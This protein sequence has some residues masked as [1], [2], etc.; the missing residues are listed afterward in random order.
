MLQWNFRSSASCPRCGI[1]LEDKDHIT[2]CPE[3][4]A[5]ST[6]QT[7]LK[8][9]KRWFRESNTAHEVAEA[10]IWGLTQWCDPQRTTAPPA[11]QFI[12]DQTVL[13]WGRLF[14][15]WLATSWRHHQEEQWRCVRSHR[16]G[17]RW[18]AELIKKLWNV[19]WDM[20]AHQ[21]GIL[22]TSP[23]A[24]QEILEKHVND[25]IRAIYE[26]GTQALPCDA[27][28]LLQKTQE[29]MLQLPLPAKHQWLESINNAIARKQKH[30]YGNY[31]SEQWFMASWVIY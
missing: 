4:E 25:K 26:G 22:H 7:S 16:S 30:E 9:L 24:R 14:D 21:N 19:S 18:V 27:I 2:Q 3:T 8:E 28:G 1:G 17:K 11:G 13:G 23:T 5:C 6:W 29:Q 12:I 10:I 20:W 31:L 15:G